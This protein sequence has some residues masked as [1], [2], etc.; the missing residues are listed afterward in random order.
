[1]VACHVAEGK[2]ED[3]WNKRMVNIPAIGNVPMFAA[4]SE[5]RTGKT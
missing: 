3:E 2:C 5:G 4:V 1:V